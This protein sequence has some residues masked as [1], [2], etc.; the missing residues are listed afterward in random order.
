MHSTVSLLGV[1]DITCSIVI[2]ETFVQRNRGN[3]WSSLT[4]PLPFPCAQL[5]ETGVI[6]IRPQAWGFPARLFYEPSHSRNRPAGR[7]LGHQRACCSPR[8]LWPW[9]R[10]L[11]WARPL[12]GA[13]VVGAVVGATVYGGRDRTVYVERQPVYYAPPR[14]TCNRH[15]SRCTTSRTTHPRH[16]PQATA[17]ITARHRCTTARHA[18]NG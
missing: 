17:L 14:C 12:L 8:R 1:V 7:C 13:A 2:T 18:G 6:V 11:V 5:T 15:H 3:H 10:W 9:R 16:R 4:Q